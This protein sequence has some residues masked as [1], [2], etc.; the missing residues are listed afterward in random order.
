MLTQTD[1]GAD[2]DGSGGPDNAHI[3]NANMTTLPDGQ[4]PT[5]QMYLFENSDSPDTL[6]P[7]SMNGGDD[8]AVVWHEYTHGLSNR[9]VTNADGSGALSTAHAGAMGEAWSDW[10][11]SDFQVADGIKDDTLATPGEI[12]VGDYSDADPHWL[13]TQALDC[14][15]GAVTAACPGGAGTGGRRTMSVTSSGSTPSARTRGVIEPRAADGGR[16]GLL[17]GPALRDGAAVSHPP[18]IKHS[19]RPDDV[20]DAAFPR[21]IRCD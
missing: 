21:G 6:D 17:S 1:D 10:Y 20:W 2:T 14:P 8:S 5:M 15:V 9:L 4:S 12:D 7:R 13:R 19:E 16:S 3:D 11:A 18:A